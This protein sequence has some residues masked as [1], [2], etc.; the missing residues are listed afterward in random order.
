MCPIVSH[1]ALSYTGNFLPAPER[2][3]QDREEAKALRVLSRAVAFDLGAGSATAG[4]CRSTKKSSGN[5]QHN[6]GHSPPGRSETASGTLRLEAAKRW[7]AKLHTARSLLAFGRNGFA[8]GVAAPCDFSHLN[9]RKTL[10]INEFPIW[11]DVRDAR[12]RGNLRLAR[13][14][15]QTG[16][17]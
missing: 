1:C 7:A 3:A 11:F 17:D 15:S 16:R 2:A 5:H 12:Q 6:D 9:I 13:W 4:R 8:A 14:S 10:P